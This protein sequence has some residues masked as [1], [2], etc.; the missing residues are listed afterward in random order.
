MRNSGASSLALRNIEIGN[1]D[2]I[3]THP[4]QVKWDMV[5][6]KARNG[7]RRPLCQFLREHGGE[8]QEVDYERLAAVLEGGLKVRKGPGGRNDPYIMA[9]RKEPDLLIAQL[10][11]RCLSGEVPD[12]LRVADMLAA[13]S[14]R[15]RRRP[16][17]TRLRQ[18]VRQEW[19]SRRIQQLRERDG[20]TLEK[21]IELV[22]AETFK[23]ESLVKQE[24]LAWKKS[25]ELD[26]KGAA[27][28]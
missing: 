3:K 23:S 17:K 9:A 20:M 12:L 19:N 22:A 28:Y 7:D 14:C 11:E 27:I 13:D 10:Q 6:F 21:A 5:V 26:S 4:L 25:K 2:N 1:M 15:R 24:Y 16:K 18:A 8:Y